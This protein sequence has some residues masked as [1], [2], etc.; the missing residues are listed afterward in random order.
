VGHGPA[1]IVGVENPLAGFDT[2]DEKIFN[3]RP[4]A[5]SHPVEILLLFRELFLI[6]G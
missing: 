4:D 2:V 5:R 6:H 1:Q 3:G